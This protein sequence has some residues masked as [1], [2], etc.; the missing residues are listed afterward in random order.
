[1]ILIFVL[2]FYSVDAA[3]LCPNGIITSQCLC[4]DYLYSSG[5]CCGNIWNPVSCSS[6]WQ[7]LYT[8]DFENGQV[9]DSPY[10]VNHIPDIAPEYR[11]VLDGTNHVL[12]DNFANDGVNN[13]KRTHILMLRL[14]NMGVNSKGEFYLK[15]D[16]KIDP[17][18]LWCCAAEFSQYCTS[19]TTNCPNGRTGAKMAY[20]FGSAGTDWIPGSDPAGDTGIGNWKLTDNRG[21]ATGYQSITTNLIDENDGE[22]HTWI[23]YFKHNTQTNGVWNNDGVFELYI[24]GARQWRITNVPYSG[25]SNAGTL[26]ETT[27][28]RISK[29][30]SYVGGG[31]HLDDSRAW[32]YWIDNISIY[33]TSGQVQEYCGDGS[34]NN[35]ETC[36]SCSQDC[37]ACPVIC[38]NGNCET[39]ETCLTCASDCGACPPGTLTQTVNFVQGWNLFTLR[40]NVSTTSSNL[41]SLFVMRYQN[42]Q[43]E[44]AW[45]S[46]SAFNLEPLRVYYVYSTG[47]KTVSFTGTA[48]NSGYNYPL[49][50]YSWNLFAVN[51]T[52]TFNSIYPSFTSLQQEIDRINSGFSYTARNAASDSLV[53]GEYYWVNIRSPQISPAY[54]SQV[55]TNDFIGGVVT[56]IYN[57]F[58]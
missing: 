13:D 23:W 58:S 19:P 54:T 38:G 51:R 44:T 11:V 40:V 39:G 7:N 4:D 28:S 1:M 22:W 12:M 8:R 6:T 14:D 53:P 47:P 46:G 17:A 41:Q 29:P 2:C 37:G 31:G 52:G 24:D 45:G 34:C 10:F 30:I 3:D 43:W 32:Y 36:S 33:S 50:D 57:I 35:G 48:L 21:G 9:L 18:N 15:A 56:F 20:A 55:K 16:V 5:Y 27:F 49:Q 25:Y 26:Y 42:N